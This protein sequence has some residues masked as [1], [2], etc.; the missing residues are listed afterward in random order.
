M[1]GL[2]QKVIGL[3]AFLVI[4]EE[5]FRWKTNYSTG[6][7]EIKPTFVISRYKLY[8]LEEI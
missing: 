2:P 6:S 4:S 1:L 3:F 7:N 8:D 5:F